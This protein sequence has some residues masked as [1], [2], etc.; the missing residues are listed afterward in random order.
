[1]ALFKRKKRAII[2]GGS[3]GGCV[4]DILISGYKPLSQNPE[5]ITGCRRIAEIVGAMTIHLMA[6]KDNGDIRVINEL[7]RKLD[8]NPN[9]YQ[10][11]FTFI[12]AIVMDLLLYGRGNAV[13]RVNTKGGLIDNLEPI[14]AYRVSYNSLDNKKFGYNIFIDG[15]K[16]DPRDLLHFVLNPKEGEPWRGAGLQVSLKNVADSLQQADVTKR[17][18][19][20]SKYKPSLIIKVDALTDEFASPE[21]RKKL[22][23]S[24]ITSG[25]AG[26]PWLIPAEQFDVEQVKPLTLND[27]A[28]SQTITLDKKTVAS[29]LGVPSFI[30][31][32]GNF[33]AAEY[34]NFINT[35]VKPI[36]VMMQ[37]ELTRKVIV[38]PKM[39]VKFNV[40]STYEYD[41]K[42]LA[43]VFGEL[44][45][46][47]IVTG[48]EVRDK[49]GLEP[50][51]GL[52]ELTM[53]ENYIPVNMSAKQKKLVQEDE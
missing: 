18:F 8:I 20:S 23:D 49:L 15:V 1:M 24:Y 47:G 14:P 27:L 44:K 50:V 38:S 53:L 34:N 6:N 12:N 19:M 2:L 5:I 28:I 51:N 41:I 16:Y 45:K 48:N 40:L 43:D 17:K 31:G 29:I 26:E 4:D 11:R 13:C 42:T 35:V 33:S 37:Q 10:T 32:V 52:D 39:Y 7:S 30:L 46:L 36:C 22:M 21:G 3:S 9:E 25:E